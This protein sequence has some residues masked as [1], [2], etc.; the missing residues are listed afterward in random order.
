V[1]GA[2]AAA[3]GE[4]GI[5]KHASV[6]IQRHSCA[7]QYREK[8]GE[9]MPPSHLAAMTAIEQCRMEAVGGQVYQCPECGEM[10][11][12]YHSC[13]NRHC[14]KCQHEAGQ[15]CAVVR[16]SDARKSSGRRLTAA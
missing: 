13:Q 15:Q 4:S 3:L 16:P 7:S 1:S 5:H 8:Y 14:P 9:R 11:Y 10:R 2:F 12:R 6:H